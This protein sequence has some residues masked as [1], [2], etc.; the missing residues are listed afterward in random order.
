VLFIGAPGP[1]PI[2]AVPR[3]GGRPREICALP[4]HWVRSNGA[5]DQLVAMLSERIVLIDPRSGS[6]TPL[7][8]RVGA[9]ARP[10][11]SP[12]GRAVIFSDR[13]ER[14]CSQLFLAF[15]DEG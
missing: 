13:D 5:G 9:E 3:L 11:F 15:L 1:G 12:D 4:C 8:S 7:C 2:M 6:A 14:G 10:C